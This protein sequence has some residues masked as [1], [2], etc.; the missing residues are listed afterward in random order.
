MRKWNASSCSTNKNTSYSTL[1]IAVY[2]MLLGLEYRTRLSPLS[3]MHIIS[4]G[5]S[6]G[7]PRYFTP[8]EKVPLTTTL[9]RQ[10]SRQKALKLECVR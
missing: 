7:R 8:M 6:S 3:W 5:C 1:S 4:A 9:R 10:S 2:D